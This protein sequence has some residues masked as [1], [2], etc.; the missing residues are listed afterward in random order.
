MPE[1]KEQPSEPEITIRNK[2]TGEELTGED[3]ARAL[4]RLRDNLIRNAALPLPDRQKTIQRLGAEIAQSTAEPDAFEGSG[5]E[6]LAQL[7]AS[8]PQA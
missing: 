6:N 5:S 3:R 2:D 1:D 8:S 7:I 4:G